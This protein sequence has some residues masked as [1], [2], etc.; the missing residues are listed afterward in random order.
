M[1][2]IFIVIP[3]LIFLMFCIGLELKLSNFKLIL[4][5]PLPIIVGSF[6]QLVFHPLVAWFVLSFLNIPD[7]FKI[8]I[9]LIAA[10]PG[11]ASSNAFSFL[12][13]GDVALSVLLTSLTSILSIFTIPIIVSSYIYFEI[14]DSV[15][16]HLPFFKLLMQNVVFLLIP[17]IIGMILNKYNEEFVKKISFLTK[18]LPI[19]L[20]LILITV[21]FLENRSVIIQNF[22]QLSIAILILVIGVMLLIYFISRLVRIQRPQRKTIVIGVGIKNAAQAILIATSPIILNNSKIAIPAVL[23]ALIMNVVVLSYV[24]LNRKV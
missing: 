8:G 4:N 1:N 24:A 21:F 19:Y 20:L 13:K 14:G 10:C 9:I 7:E 22:N 2:S 18:K 23:Y 16:F 6:A 11:G 5:Q 12:A 3:V 17:I 15:N